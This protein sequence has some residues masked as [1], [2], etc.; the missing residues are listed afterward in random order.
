MTT[1][2]HFHQSSPLLG[3]PMASPDAEPE[4][5][6]P[7]SFAQRRLWFLQ[8]LEP[9]QTSY[10]VPRAW[11]LSGPLDVGA[12]NFAL[13]RIV[14][15][16]DTLRT[17]FVVQDGEPAQV[18]HP[19]RPFAVAVEDISRT[20]DPGAVAAEIALAEANTPFDLAVGDLFRARVLHLAAEEHV[21]LYA[22]HHIVNDGWSNALWMREFTAFYRE[23]VSGEPAGIADLEIQYG[24]YAAWQQDYLTGNVLDDQLAFWKRALEGAPTLL[25]L[26]SDRP[27]PR[28]VSPEGAR[29]RFALSQPL[30]QELRK[31]ARE[32]NSTLFMVMLAAFEV[33][34]SRY[35]GQ[36][37]FLLGT[38]IANRERLELEPLIGLFNNVLL[39]RGKV[40]PGASFK[41]LLNEVKRF[42]L[43]AYAH[44]EM[45]F[46]K[47]VEH[48]QPARSLSY[49]PLFQVMF[50]L[51]NT[52]RAE[53]SLPGLTI[54]A[55]PGGRLKTNQDMYISVEDAPDHLRGVVEYSKAIFDQTTIERMLGHYQRVL[56]SMVDNPSAKFSE[57]PLLSAGE[58]KR[59]TSD[60]N[61]TAENYP[62]E[63]CL[64]ELISQ[65]AALRPEA[66]AALFADQRLSYA[67]L[68]ARSNRLA[69]HLQA[70]GVERGQ[71]VGIY[72]DR[73]LDL[74]VSLLAVMKSGAA[75]VPLDPNYP[76]KRVE[77]I[78]QDAGASCLVTKSGLRGQLTDFHEPVVLLDEEE[79]A[80]AEQAS[81][82]VVSGVTPEDLVYVIFTS[83]S[84]GRPKGVEVPHRAVVNLMT[85]MS[86]ELTMGPDD[87][88]PALASFGFDMSIPELYLPLVTGGTLALG[89][90]HLAGNGE[91]LAQFLRRQHAT[92]V[93]ATP[94]TWNL[95]LDCEFTGAGLKRCIGA[96]PLP[97]GLFERLMAAAPG[98][99]L[100][101]F[102]GPTE[103]TVWSTYHRFTS[104]DETIVVGRP[105]ANTQVYILDRNG[106]ICPIGV[107]GEIHIAGD[108][109]AL[110]YS[111]QPDLT[112]EKFVP[113]PFSADPSSRMYRTA[114][115]GRWT[116]GGAI[117]H[118]G[119]IDNQVKIRGFRIELG[120]IEAAL[121]SQP[122][123][124]EAV[125][126]VREDV[127]GDKRL[128]AYVAS[129]ATLDKAELRARLKELLPDYMVPAA[130]HQLA[131]L[132]LTP[133]G[134][135]D[136]KALP[137]PE[138]EQAAT[139]SEEASTPTEEIVAGIWA[140][141]LR[142]DKIGVVD[143]FFTLGG[144]SLLATQVISRIRRVLDVDL[145]LRVIFDTPTVRGIAVQIEASRLPGGAVAT[146][147]LIRVERDRPLPLSFG[148]QRFWFLDQLE[149][150][151][152][153]ANVP[154]RW[155]L[156]GSLELGV[157]ESA[158]TEIVSRHEV[159]RTRYVV[160]GG[161]PVQ[162]I[163]APRPVPVSV[164]DL[165]SVAEGDR[166]ARARAVA[167]EEVNRAFDLEHGPIFRAS[168]V[169]L[170]EQDHVLIV[171]TH[172]IATD[173]W[174]QGVLR[175]EL[176]VLYEA[177]LSG[178]PSPLPPLPLQYADYAVWQRGSLA[179]EA[180]ERQLA[181]WR[182][183]LRDAPVSIA[184]P[185]D[186]PRPAVQTY[187]GASRAAVLPAELIERL[188]SLSLDEG[189][190]LYMTLLSA[191][192]ALLSRYSGQQDIVVGSAIAGRTQRDT[193]KLIGLFVNSLALRTDLSGE[194]TF[195]DLVQRVR[196]AT[197]GAYS[198]QD[199][200][201]ERLVEELN[202]V[203]DSSRSPLYQVMLILQNLPPQ[204]TQMPG[205]ELTGFGT[206]NET[207]QMDL[208]LNL[209]EHPGGM[210]ATLVYNT[211]LY[212]AGTASRMLE[213]YQC[214]LESVAANP[215][216]AVA[217][218]SLL[219]AGEL[220]QLTDAWNATEA[221]YPREA[222]VHGLIAARA[223][224]RPEATA[225]LFGRER[226]SY[227]E[228]EE[229]SNRLARH[230]AERGIGRG[231]RVGV[232]LDRSLELMVS[233]LAVM[234]TGAAYV[235]LDTHYPSRRVESILEDAAVKCLLTRSSL[236][237]RLAE[238]GG[239]LLLD[240]EAD[241]IA[242]QSGEGFASAATPDDLVYIIFTSGSTGRP[243]GVEIRHG[244][245][246]NLLTAMARDLA[247]GPGDVFPAL[248]S[249]GF[250]MS[251]PELYLP[252][253]T[254]GTL[255]LAEA[256]LAGNGED[257][258]RFL[259]R[260]GATIVHATPTTWTLLL[261]AGFTAQGL[262]RCIGAEPLPQR[263]FERLMA[264]APDT[265]LWNF[266]GPTET[267]VWS[268]VHRFTS[269]E[270]P[271]VVGRPLANQQVY[272]L[273]A[274]G[275]V[276]PI[277]VPGEICIAGAGVARGYCDRPDLTAEKFVPNPFDTDPAARMYRTSDLGRWTAEGTIEHLGRADNQVKIR[278]FRIELG[279]IE[280]ALATLP[281]I[282]EAV[283]IAREDT[284]GDK[285]LV[286][287]LVS[288]SG[289]DRAAL[290]AGLK[291]TLPDYMVPS[292][293]VPLERLP[294]NSNG[295]VDRLH[296]PAPAGDEPSDHTGH[297]PRTYM[298]VLLAE[299]WKD[300]LKIN[301]VK[302]SDDFFELGG[303]SLLAAAMINKLS[304]SLGYR[305][306]LAA[307]FE[308]PTLGA[309]AETAE[310][311]G[312]DQ[313]QL[314]SIVPIHRSGSKPALY[315]V[316]RPNVNS[317]GFV[318]LSRA[319]SGNLPVYGLQSNMDNDG[320]LAPF[321]QLEYEE[322]A[323]E[324][325]AALREIQPEGPY[326]LT[327]FCEGA[328]IAFEMARQ[329]E[330]MN[331]EVGG[332]FILDVWPVENT[333]D[334][335]RYMLGRYFSVI[336]RYWKSIK[337]LGL[338]PVA[339][340]QPDLLHNRTRQFV[341]S[342]LLSDPA[343]RKLLTRR[344][345]ARY[346]PGKDFVPTM[347]DG[348]AVVFRTAKQMFYRVHDESL[349]WAKRVRGSV[350][351]VQVP[352]THV[353]ILREPGVS[354]VARELEA[355]IDAYL[356][357][358][359]SGAPAKTDRP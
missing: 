80:I 163:D 11:R 182:E 283:V 116:A 344:M 310:R 127:P 320:I 292:A 122:G 337:R 149:Q 131:Q 54:S 333:V 266:Y 101:N 25:D 16:H 55:V 28:L 44:Q 284:P 121:T 111:A 298:E 313:A 45:P 209:V 38:P 276:C 152:S 18:V 164:H 348:N 120:E 267:T 318:F 56:E 83:G 277:G 17:A 219:P 265:P 43:D 115:L 334:R 285:R 280:T 294:L 319:L 274:A 14:E 32:S 177:Y 20:P 243:K 226:L 200:P 170:S 93:H 202:P 160:E 13:N 222:C 359:T 73:S 67:E 172:H 156:R 150:G 155:R 204:Q 29:V 213:H 271:I 251:V 238:R 74:A 316:S 220:E 303:H 21:L 223:A 340:K 36:E 24:D 145:P 311:Q 178:A 70:R 184:L 342:A 244:A 179:G 332:L 301:F 225:V 208:L 304:E 227:G 113:N 7:A 169:K 263:V 50:A 5:L 356:A 19:Y 40:K 77:G 51:Q 241:A 273:D 217:E 3:T 166:E 65:Q 134:K 199:V 329:F 132:P 159:L 351:V 299:I 256:Y 257:L 106:Q 275:R 321:T 343:G 141:V 250:D 282:R 95:L 214:L 207:S 315:C 232:Y 195:H 107:A 296:L 99:P 100:W 126:I 175:H 157:L 249:V 193:E 102:Y 42:T 23:K 167:G 1:E 125:V 189:A 328:H 142:V 72:L 188:K 196:A 112:A 108:G 261:D 186:K 218:L 247:M 312:I 59:L 197:V 290:R 110:G 8:Q 205:L 71:R 187:R 79:M 240:E 323:A 331:L 190:T 165:S 92:L 48:L 75:Y 87:V 139:G 289:L 330:A 317:L 151:S 346:W 137:A 206:A 325:I 237:D 61:A 279:E 133:N 64:H 6:F 129:N 231:D 47:L 210:S 109:V 46:E 353:L 288:D 105:L 308:A 224:E 349:G 30:T 233:L 124:S 62:R 212:E 215:S 327:G 148:Q 176:S 135:V 153:F 347:Y 90:A 57:A 119:R 211:D 9:D 336:R 259:V 291:E 295:K 78:L 235:P 123:V 27:R 268:T 58:L 52:P 104:A 262:K 307:L 254:G 171:S 117:E 4:Y 94:T 248:A 272:I 180:L 136:R 341:D 76:A 39:I 297:E 255:A 230:L 302:T 53:A 191:F 69:R 114:D 15:R 245:V 162:V 144:H 253:A 118:L 147:P 183:H 345:E 192:F 22:T 10:L 174:S 2:S 31:L 314:A 234:K 146:P 34:V 63:R 194:P 103:T 143:D 96:E 354:V 140:Q 269:A 355:R 258:A 181:Y 98:T 252:L 352:G 287:Y 26:P 228:L 309:L 97:Q 41:E 86:K 198:H 326:F 158:L 37:D 339:R 270:E 49:N 128:V 203:R 239:L 322:K 85:W 33:L 60:C 324:Y 154:L 242:R 12:V 216:V 281:S 264:A 229:R 286:A 173:G 68:E 138:Y 66:T 278:G 246:V 201:F 35:S 82:P 161:D 293:F 260:H 91:E 300:I 350:E 335:K 357:R 338:S 185:T 88:F 358:R 305:V 81:G 168:L 130:F 306:R 84:T 89:E 236:K 221:D